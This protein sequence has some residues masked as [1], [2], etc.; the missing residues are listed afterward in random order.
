ME[1]RTE[2]MKALRHRG[3]S[4]QAIGDIFN[5]SRA[6]VH[7]IISGYGALLISMNSNG[8]YG[9]LRQTVLERDNHKC[10]KCGAVDDLVV[11]HVD[12]NDRNNKL[13]NLVTI[14]N[15]CHLDLHGPGAFVPEVN[16][17]DAK[18]IKELR[19]RLGLTQKELGA[20]VKADVITVS[21]WEL[22]KQRPSKEAQWRLAKFNK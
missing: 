3:L 20:R 14:C 11:H 19:E 1:D 16:D 5:L 13:G 17:M 10:S 6:R 18:Q 12:G 7:Q 2:R 4:Y 9:T 8:W 15:A 21:R 22:G